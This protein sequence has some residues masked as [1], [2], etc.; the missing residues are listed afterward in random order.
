[1]KD[2]IVKGTHIKKE[3]SILLLIFSLVFIVNI[4]A[5][6]SYKT[7]WSEVITSLGF[8]VI[9]AIVLYLLVFGIRLMVKGLA[10]LIKS[11][12]TLS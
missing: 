6:I 7:P 12:K 11:K 5:I 9:F 10:Q 4:Y 2:I 3:V 8:V 1:M